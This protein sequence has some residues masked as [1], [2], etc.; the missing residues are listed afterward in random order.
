[1]TVEGL[2]QELLALGPTAL[3]LEVY[4]GIEP[5]IKVLYVEERHDDEDYVI[6]T[7]IKESDEGQ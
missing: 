7:T 3:E 1:M 2:I 5:G 6:L 4:T